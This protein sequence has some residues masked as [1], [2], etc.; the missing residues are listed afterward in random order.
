VSDEAE[1]TPLVTEEHEIFTQQAHR[2]TG[3]TGS[4][5]SSTAVPTGCQ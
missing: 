2:R 4:A 1:S 3:C 5:S